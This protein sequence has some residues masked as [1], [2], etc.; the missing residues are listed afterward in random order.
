MKKL[1]LL[2][3]TLLSSGFVLAKLPA[4][5]PEQ[6]AAADLAKARTDHGNRVANYQLCLS[7][8]EVANKYRKAG[9]PA[10][11]ACTNPGP[12]VPPVAAPAPAAAPAAPAAKK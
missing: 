10:P 5:T 2:L 8:N 4:P 11:G 6:A 7:Q 9:T 1:S 12:F 3:V